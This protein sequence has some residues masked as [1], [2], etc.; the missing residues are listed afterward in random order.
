MNVDLEKLV[1]RFVNIILGMLLAL[2]LMAQ[3][4]NLEVMAQD[5]AAEQVAP[6]PVIEYT[7][8]RKT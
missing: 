7:M 3:A 1:N 6:M 5:A 8:Q 4:E 2:P